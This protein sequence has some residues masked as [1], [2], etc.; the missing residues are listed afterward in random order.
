MNYINTVCCMYMYLFIVS[1]STHTCLHS[2]L[3]FDSWLCVVLY[4]CM[5]VYAPQ[6]SS[7]PK[8]IHIS[9]FAL[10]LEYNFMEEKYITWV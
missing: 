4:V 7:S 5:C 8:C 1:I 3:H 6:T 10:D 9:S 2:K